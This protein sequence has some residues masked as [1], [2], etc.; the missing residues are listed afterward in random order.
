[1]NYLRIYSMLVSRAQQRSEVAGYSEIHHII[2]KSMGGTNSI[3]NLV[4]FTGREHFISH[5][6]LSKIY[7]NSGMQHAIWRMANTER[8]RKVTSRLYEQLRKDHSTR[9]SNDLEANKKRASHGESNGMWNKTHT[10]EA[11]QRI[12][13]ANLQKVQCPYCDKVGGVAIMQRWHFE[14]CKLSA[15]YIPPRKMKRLSATEETRQKISN[16]LLGKTSLKK[17]KKQKRDCS[18]EYCGIV[19]GKGQHS[20]WHGSNCKKKS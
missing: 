16:S 14:N 19:C 11:K 15:N 7:P 20:R 13:D 9:I 6:L 4:R 8:Y 17:G 1:M 10:E 12:R 3:V 5:R 18:C 2:P